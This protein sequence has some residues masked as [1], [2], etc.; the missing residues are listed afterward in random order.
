M[1]FSDARM[2]PVRGD[3]WSL[4]CEKFSQDSTAPR[5]EATFKDKLYSSR[6]YRAC[7]DQELPSVERVLTFCQKSP[8]PKNRTILGLYFEQQAILV[9]EHHIKKMTAQLLQPTKVLDAPYLQNDYYLHVLDAPRK[10]K[11]DNPENQ[12]AVAL[13]HEVYTTL[14]DKSRVDK[15]ATVANTALITCLRCIPQ[16]RL[17]LGANDAS[18]QIV[19]LTTKRKIYNARLAST[20]YCAEPI[21]ATTSLL[22]MFDGSIVQKDAR[23]PRRTNMISRH[24]PQRI[25][26][27]ALNP[28]GYRLASGSNDN[29]IKLWD[30]RREGCLNTF[31][32]HQSAIRALAWSP[33]KLD[34]LFSGGGLHDK[35]I[36]V[37]NVQ[38]AKVI[39]SEESVQS[40]VSA[41]H[42]SADDS[43]LVSCHGAPSN[44]AIVWKFDD[45]F[46]E[47]AKL[48]G[49]STRI[50]QSTLLTDEKTLITAGADELICV[51]NVF[52]KRKPHLERKQSA[53][54]LPTIR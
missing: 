29:S 7:F 34:L 13:A 39:A 20:I 11:T 6:L 44:S 30:I 24:S 14:L 23:A 36:K 26:S 15:V 40:P 32:V 17:L 4:A 1:S 37:I 33:S 51:W 35:T 2:I 12:L 28:D 31:D 25:C 41:I 48:Q 27:L 54:T 43:Q 47:R 49:H 42:F 52:E 38:Q 46:H 5:A 50:L 22:G 53:L 10:S 3:D 16:N 45:G 9:R 19:D 18:W 21:D 8:P